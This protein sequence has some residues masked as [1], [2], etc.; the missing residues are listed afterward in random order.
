MY[1]WAS[2]QQVAVDPSLTGSGG[3]GGWWSSNVKSGHHSFHDK[4]AT[5]GLLETTKGSGAII[6]ITPSST[7]SDNHYLNWSSCPGSNEV[8]LSTRIFFARVFPISIKQQND[9][10]IA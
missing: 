8:T 3:G 5:Q 1:Q 2:R 6:T 9:R 4:G 7:V 10:T